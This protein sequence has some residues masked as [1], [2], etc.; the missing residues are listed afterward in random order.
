MVLVIIILC[1]A[2]FLENTVL[3]LLFRE[4]RHQLLKVELI[5]QAIEGQM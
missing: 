3:V 4:Y 2:L 5:T 1:M